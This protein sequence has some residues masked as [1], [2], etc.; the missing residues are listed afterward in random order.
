MA[1]AALIQTLVDDRDLTDLRCG[2]LRVLG[3][4]IRLRIVAYLCVADEKTVSEITDALALPQATVSQQLASLRLHGLVQA[5]KDKGY[6]H[7]SIAMPRVAELI[8]CLA[9]CH[10]EHDPA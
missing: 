4:P 7:Y 6:R 9:K 3:N 1:D 2:V 8:T 10:G 5:R